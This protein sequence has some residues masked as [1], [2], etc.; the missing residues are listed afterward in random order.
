MRAYSV[1]R[2]VS[3]GTYPKGFGL[4]GIVNFDRREFV[5][6]IGRPAWGCIDY[7]AEVPRDVLDR[8][9]L[10]TVETEARPQLPEPRIIARIARMFAS[11][12]DDRG[13]KLIGIAVRH[14]YDEDAVCDAVSAELEAPAL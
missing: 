3:I 12:D 8:Y 14:G 4:S 2:S 7:G 11:G 9:E 6:E 13:R 10:K 1:N 5:D